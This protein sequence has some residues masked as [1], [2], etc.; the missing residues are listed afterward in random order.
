MRIDI[1]THILPGIDDGAADEEIA[2]AMLKKA[3]EE[4]T[5]VLV[6]TPH[7][8]HGFKDSWEEKRRSAWETVCNMAAEISPDLQIL[9]GA[10]LFFESG[11][12]KDLED[13]RELTLNHTRSVLIEFSMDTSYLYIK[14][15]VLN[16]Q[17][18]GYVPILAHVERYSAL[19]R[20]E[21]VRELVDMGVKI[22]ANSDSVTGK[23]GWGIKRYLKKLMHEDLIDLVAT[24][25]HDLDRRPP[26]MDSCARYLDRKMGAGYSQMVCGDNAGKLLNMDILC[27]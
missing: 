25:A 19:A 10:E 3:Y 27:Y 12:L 26:G 18:M 5:K 16:L 21:R 2:F 20:M 15:A 4:G 8:R 6:A 23:N 14:N 13:R 17:G 22:Q 9:L 24:D 11:I 7:Y 1:H